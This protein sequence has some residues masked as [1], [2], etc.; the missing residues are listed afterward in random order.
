M[1]MQSPH[2][3][4]RLLLIYNADSGLLNSARESLFKVFAPS[5]V[6]CSL[7][8]LTH[9]LLTVKSDWRLFLDSLPLAIDEYHRDEFAEAFPDL[10]IALPAIMVAVGENEPNVLIA[11]HEIDAMS[12]LD[13][14][15]ERVQDRLID[16]LTRSPGM[17]LA[18]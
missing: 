18:D 7:C 13:Q 8:A 6:S 9:G 12:H 3:T 17:R 1:T 5:K 2:R 15:S 16:L 4:A 14:L 10:D 11:A